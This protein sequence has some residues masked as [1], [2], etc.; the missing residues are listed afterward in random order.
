MQLDAARAHL[1]LNARVD[2]GL[3]GSIRLPAMLW[4]GQ[5]LS[6]EG[7]FDTHVTLY[8]PADNDRDT[9]CVCTPDLLTFLIDEAPLFDAES[10]AATSWS[11]VRVRHPA[12][13]GATPPHGAATRP[14]RPA[15]RWSRGQ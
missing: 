8:Y 10:A 14:R 5:L 6:L 13:R 2:N 9:L 1:L 12:E 15:P 3:T 4:R 7:G 11:R